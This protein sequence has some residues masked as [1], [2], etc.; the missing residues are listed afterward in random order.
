MVSLQVIGPNV[1]PFQSSNQNILKVYAYTVSFIELWQS[2]YR[3]VLIFRIN[4]LKNYL[5]TVHIPAFLWT[6]TFYSYI[7]FQ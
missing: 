4:L 5:I 3:F 1:E 2:Q 6:K 7:S